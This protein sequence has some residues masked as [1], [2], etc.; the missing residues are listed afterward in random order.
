MIATPIFRASGAL[1]RLRS[2]RMETEKAKLSDGL[3]SS[4]NGLRDDDLQSSISNDRR[5][6]ALA[7]RKQSKDPRDSD[8]ETG[9]GDIRAGRIG[10][11]S[12]VKLS[13][14]RKLQRS[15]TNRSVGLNDSADFGNDAS[16]LSDD[17]DGDEGGAKLD[18]EEE[19]DDELVDLIGISQPA[20][21]YPLQFLPRSLQTEHETQPI[22]SVPKPRPDVGSAVSSCLRCASGLSCGCTT[23]GGPGVD[24]IVSEYQLL[25]SGI[26]MIGLLNNNKSNDREHS[27][28]ERL[29]AT[30]SRAK[31][32]DGVLPSDGLLNTLYQV[33]G[34]FVGNPPVLTEVMLA[35]D[36]LNANIQTSFAKNFNL[37]RVTQRTL[38]ELKSAIDEEKVRQEVL[39][40]VE[41]THQSGNKTKLSKI[42]EDLPDENTLSNK[43]SGTGFHRSVAPLDLLK[44]LVVGPVLSIG[45]DPVIEQLSQP[46]IPEP[47]VS[48]GGELGQWPEGATK[49]ILGPIVARSDSKHIKRSTLRVHVHTLHIKQHPLMNA[50][51]KLYAILKGYYAKYILVYEQRATGYLSYRLVAL[52]I[53]IRKISEKS[54][55]DENDFILLKGCYN[56]LIETLPSLIDLREAIDNLAGIMYQS[57]KDLQDARLKQ[58]FVNTKATFVARKLVSSSHHSTTSTPMPSSNNEEV[59]ATNSEGV[60]SRRGKSEPSH[61]GP[62][63]SGICQL[64]T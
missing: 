55:L 4:G 38:R 45:E 54:E 6:S 16:G 60:R 3:S 35:G 24:S 62:I 21:I 15:S 23:G 11:R 64:Y 49:E 36:S 9:I 2:K 7:R 63:L 28:E 46:V 42:T 39:A 43:H 1:E 47:H 19:L 13:S 56:D 29:L 32:V 57:W 14:N 10:A 17:G 12:P 50:E 59:A 37:A 8:N 33:D 25:R 22:L 58:G 34:L 27:E 20:H 30:D 40:T 18:V 48:Y 26:S 41:T 31:V 5:R 44:Q 53:G 51:E 61:A 52:I